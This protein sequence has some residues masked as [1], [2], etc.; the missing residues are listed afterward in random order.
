MW[1]RSKTFAHPL[2]MAQP[3]RQECVTVIECSS[4]SGTS[5]PSYIIFNCEHILSSWMPTAPPSGWIITT[6]TSGWTTNFPWHA[7]DST[8]Q[9]TNQIP[10]MNI[11]KERQSGKHAILHGQT[12]I[13]TPA[14]F[15]RLYIESLTTLSNKKPLSLCISIHEAFVVA[16][17][18][19]GAD[20]YSASDEL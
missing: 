12:I 14:N 20:F 5:I 15:D 2:Y 16:V 3:R 7:M 18:I 6:N 13:T 10:S 17:D 4:A 1:R 8:F 19:S 9:H 11:R